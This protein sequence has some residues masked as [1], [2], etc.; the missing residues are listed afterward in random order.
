[1]LIQT[2]LVS[3]L[4]FN[5]TLRRGRI[6]VAINEYINMQNLSIA[7]NRWLDFD[8]PSMPTNFGFDRNPSI[9]FQHLKEAP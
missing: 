8:N 6:M 1:M 7:F 3:A 4:L 9:I 5:P 2:V